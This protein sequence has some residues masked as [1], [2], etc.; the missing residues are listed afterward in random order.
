MMVP[1]VQMEITAQLTYNAC[2]IAYKEIQMPVQSEATRI[3]HLIICAVLIAHHKKTVLG[4][5]T[6]RVLIV[7]LQ[8][9][10]QEEL[11]MKVFAT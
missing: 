3:V 6:L 5:S 9:P 10:K 1:N 7:G 11:P 4:P 8:P 2:L